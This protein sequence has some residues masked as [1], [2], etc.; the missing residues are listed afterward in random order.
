MR[1]SLLCIILSSLLIPAA[2]AATPTVGDP[3]DP[4]GLSKQI[5]NAYQG[6]AKSIKITPGRYEMPVGA[7]DSAS[8][9]LHD[10]KD[11]TID[12]TGVEIAAQDHKDVAGFYNC[13]NVTFRGATLH[14]DRPL[15]GQAKILK[16]GHDDAGDFYDA[17][18]DPGFLRTVT[19]GSSYIFDAKTRQW[20]R[21]TWD[22]GAKKVEPID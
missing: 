6:G 21:G 22:M 15:T 20:K 18:I 8:L 7:G 12:A 16:L 10:M 19:F 14:Y 17:Q 9:A 2:N 3:S 5:A 11:F 1:N 4:G 13:T